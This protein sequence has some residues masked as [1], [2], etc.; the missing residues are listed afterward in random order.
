VL[1]VATT[2]W[3]YSLLDIGAKYLFA[4]LL[5]RWVAANERV[6]E[7]VTTGQATG[8]ATPADD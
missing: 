5:L 8:A 2:S 3:G 6:V 4:F 7:G 1:G